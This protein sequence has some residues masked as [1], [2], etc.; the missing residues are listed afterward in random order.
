MPILLSRKSFCSS[1][2]PLL[3]IPAALSIDSNT[4]II[5]AFWA[6]FM[7]ASSTIRRFCST[8]KWDAG[9]LYPPSPAV[10]FSF[11]SSSSFFFQDH[12]CCRYC[13]FHQ[14]YPTKMAPIEPCPCGPAS[15]TYTVRIEPLWLIILPE[16]CYHCYLEGPPWPRVGRGPRKRQGV[17]SL[18]GM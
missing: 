1:S 2:S 10:P 12:C 8:T 14:F 3:V 18:I 4:S 15:I 17:D 9:L 11:P 5:A 16:G 7:L 13:F 6:T